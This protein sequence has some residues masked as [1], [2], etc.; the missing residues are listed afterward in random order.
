VEAWL[1]AFPTSIDHLLIGHSAGSFATLRGEY[2]TWPGGTLQWADALAR[3]RPGVVQSIALF[4]GPVVIPAGA[5]AKAVPE[6]YVRDL[7]KEL[8]PLRVNAVWTEPVRS[9]LQAVSPV[10]TRQALYLFPFGQ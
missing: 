9:P 1:A 2:S 5:A 6:G 4:S 8:S 10:Q 3:S 7:A